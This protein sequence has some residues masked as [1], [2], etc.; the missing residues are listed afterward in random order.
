M[1][2]P[3]PRPRP[4]SQGNLLFSFCKVVK[5]FVTYLLAL[6]KENYLESFHN[7]RPTA[8]GDVVWKQTNSLHE[9]EDLDN[10]LYLTSSYFITTNVALANKIQETSC[11]IPL[12]MIL[13][14]V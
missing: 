11:I 3:G 1:F 6:A 12:S 4:A 7:T 10:C 14:N 2:Q 13:C 8:T 9:T 5:S